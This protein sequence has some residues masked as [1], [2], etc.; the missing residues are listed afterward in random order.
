[1]NL[2]FFVALF[3]GTLGKEN[4]PDSKKLEALT[5]SIILIILVEGILSIAVTDQLTELILFMVE[6]NIRRSVMDVFDKEQKS[7][8]SNFR[9]QIIRL[10]SDEGTW[11]YKNMNMM[12]CNFE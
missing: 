8:K 3:C 1:M 9:G 6:I 4:Q 11:V 10:Y 12:Y 5:S 2:A 7:L